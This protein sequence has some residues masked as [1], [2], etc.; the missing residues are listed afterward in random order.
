MDHLG[1]RHEQKNLSSFKHE[2]AI[3][4]W[5]KITLTLIM[6]VAGEANLLT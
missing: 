1:H 4:L 2:F 5:E 6:C 3:L